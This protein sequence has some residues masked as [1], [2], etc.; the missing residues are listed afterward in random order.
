MKPQKLYFSYIAESKEGNNELE[1]EITTAMETIGYT[2]HASN[3]Y[4]E[5]Y[6]RELT[7]VRKP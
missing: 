3:I 6:R 7:F 4:A 2:L 5:T 1:A